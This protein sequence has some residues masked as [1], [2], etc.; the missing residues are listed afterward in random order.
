MGE[1]VKEACGVFGVFG[2]PNAAYS[3]YLGSYAQQH[4]GMESC[5]I[6]SSDGTKVYV[7]TGMGLVPDVFSAEHFV[8]GNA[9]LKGHIAGAH[10]RYSTTGNSSLKNA[11]PMTLDTKFGEISVSH[12]GNLTNAEGLKRKLIDEYAKFKSTTDSEVIL[13][14]IDRAKA[15]NL[16]D[17]IVE[18]LGRVIGSYSLILT[19]K[20]TLYAVRDPNGFRPLCIGHRDKAIMI[21]SEEFALALNDAKY[22]REVNPGELITVNADTISNEHGY[23]S[24]QLANSSSVKESRCIFEG[25][26]FARPDHRIKGLAVAV[27]RRRFGQQL[28]REHPVDA[29]IVVPIPDSGNFAALGYS[30]E[31][32]I[33]LELAYVRSHFGGRTFMLPDQ[34]AREV[35]TK[36]KLAVVKELVEGKRAIVV[37]DSIIRGTTSKNRITLLREAGA[38]EVHLRVSCPP[39]KDPCFYGF[40]FSTYEELIAANKSIEEIRRY[41]GADTLGYLSLEGMLAAAGNENGWCTACW[42]GKYP[43]SID[44]FKAGL[45]SGK[46]N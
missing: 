7:Q 10:V 44:D 4:R 5:G 19:S 33:P 14:L 38:K 32:K 27:M 29:D 2:H 12:N 11:Q 21:A 3:A 26:Y 34:N 15:N 20:D 16:E 8:N 13:H 37:D 40:D 25:V 42:T 18:A 1:E 45:L 36:V 31:S 6:T 41:V 39:T 9:I 17:A 23:R 24:R 28:A 43:T 35:A 22:H 46:K 30:V